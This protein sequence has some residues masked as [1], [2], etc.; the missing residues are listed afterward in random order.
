MDEL[1]KM[2]KFKKWCKDHTEEIAYTSVFGGALTGVIALI[3][4]DYKDQKRRIESYNA[5]V[6]DT[7]NWLNEQQNDGKSVFQITD[8]RY[9]VIPS[10]TQRELVIK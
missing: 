6:H 4:V 7:N 1:S 9:L 5:W 10:E 8:G 3:V 2:Q